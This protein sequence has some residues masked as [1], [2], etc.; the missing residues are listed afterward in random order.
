MPTG[1]VNAGNI[2]D[3]LAAGAVAVG[4][5]GELCSSAAMAAGRWDQIEAT[6]RE[7]SAALRSARENRS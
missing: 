5:G 3:W 2:K 7:F 1:G 6:A 4:A